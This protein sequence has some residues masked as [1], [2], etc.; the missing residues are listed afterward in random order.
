MPKLPIFT[1]MTSSLVTLST[2]L[3]VITCCPLI[4]TA[5]PLGNSGIQ[6]SIRLALENNNKILANENT[7]EAIKLR[8]QA[9]EESKRPSINL[10]Y[11]VSINRGQINSGGIGTSYGSASRS[12]QISLNWTLFDGFSK[13]YRIQAMKCNL[14][15]KQAMFN[16]TNTQ[17]KN[18]QGQIAGAVVR[19][20]IDLSKIQANL[21]FNQQFLDNLKK[22]QSGASTI[23]E[24]QESENLVNAI[25]IE[26][27]NLKSQLVLA[28]QNYQY[29][30][31]LPPPAQINTLKEIIDSID[32]PRNAD[33]ALQIALEK[34]P[35]IKTARYQV[36][37]SK[38]NYKSAKADTYAPQVS[39]NAS[40]NFG[41]SSH[42]LIDGTTSNT[43]S[44]R[45]GI[46]VSYRFQPGSSTTLAAERKD[47]DSDQNNLDGVIDDIK[48]QISSSYPDL[49]NSLNLSEQYQQSYLNSQSHITEYL[50]NID[51]HKPIS[52]SDAIKEF[53]NLMGTWYS[54]Q[55]NTLSIVNSKF[56]IQKTIGTLFE[57][58]GLKTRGVSRFGEDE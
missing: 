39:L 11:N 28:A 33:Q 44:A 19:G 40:K 58:L 27:T 36:E 48:Q 29:L 9:A 10:N 13:D 35:E 1:K 47:I 53:N 17:Q 45:I 7:L 26:L 37:C 52:V 16:S 4:A 41:D 6:E 30:V 55:Q 46:T 12:G 8:I 24:K 5:L 51:D 18:T 56:Q 34:S 3:T 23:G 14:S 49:N 21:E 50:K 2:S 43:S 38:L 20:Y 54:Y 25:N 42:D 22:V 31:T 32:I 57:N 15:Q